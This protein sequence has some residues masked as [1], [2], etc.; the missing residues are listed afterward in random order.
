RHSRIDSGKDNRGSRRCSRVH[1]GWTSLYSF[2]LTR[3]SGTTGR[4]LAAVSILKSF[5]AMLY[6][7]A[8]FIEADNSRNSGLT[9]QQRG[10]FLSPTRA[11]KRTP[12][13]LT[14][15]R[16]DI[17][18]GYDNVKSG[19]SSQACASLARH[20]GARF[21]GFGH[22]EICNP[23][24]ALWARRMPPASLAWFLFAHG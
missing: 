11:L 14:G 10:R 9:N 15:F 17:F 19:F 13:S 16:N 4:C 24:L 20:H 2:W 5:F 22:L 8:R 18:Q 21:A 12:A 7:S 23:Q 3:S 1:D 6:L